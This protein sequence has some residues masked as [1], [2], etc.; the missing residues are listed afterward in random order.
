MTNWRE[1]LGDFIEKTEGRSR[2]QIEGSALANFIADVVIPA[3]QELKIELEKYGRQVT[4]RGAEASATL[5]VTRNGEEEMSYRLLGRTFPNT[6]VPYA[7]VR[8]RERQGLRFVSVEAM[9]RSGPPNYT[10]ADVSKDE[11]I[12][13]FLDHYMRRVRPTREED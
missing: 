10:L 7:E 4:I 3:F 13:N 6:V 5:L 1:S 11:V 2:A 9:L 8:Y 12:R